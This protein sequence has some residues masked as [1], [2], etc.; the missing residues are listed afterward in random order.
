MY[1]RNER[2]IIIPSV[3][4]LSSSKGLLGGENQVE[5]AVLVH[6]LPVQLR[7]RHGDGGEGGGVHQEE[8]CLSWVELE[9][10]PDDLH[11]LP[12]RHVVRDEE[13]GLVQHRQLLLSGEPLDDAGN[14]AGVLGP[15]LLHVLHPQSVTSPLLE[16]LD[17]IHYLVSD[18]PS[19][20]L[21][22]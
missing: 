5:E 21:F 13:L 17:M 9:S 22:L 10:S 6:L 20:S 8:E 16:R 3:R 15:D 4:S 14:L 2:T 11:Q 18:V 19:C 7:H 12:H 1:N